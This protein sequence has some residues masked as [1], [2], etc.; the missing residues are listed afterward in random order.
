MKPYQTIILILIYFFLFCNISSA[1]N[2]PTDKFHKGIFCEFWGAKT[3]GTFLSINYDYKLKKGKTNGLGLRVGVGQSIY[4]GGG[5][6]LPLEINYNPR[7]IYPFE[8]GFGTIY[9]NKN[10]IMPY[11]PIGITS[12]PESGFL[13]KLNTGPLY[14]TDTNVMSLYLG[15]ALGYSFY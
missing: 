10:G 12:R 14:N 6:M 1:Q 13:F 4:K 8:I 15:M 2:E 7:V 9:A 3:P 11:I 5:F